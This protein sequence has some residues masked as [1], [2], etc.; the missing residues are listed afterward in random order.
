MPRLGVAPDCSYRWS[1]RWSG[2]AAAV[3]LSPASGTA[4]PCLEAAL[5]LTS[6]ARFQALLLVA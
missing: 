3:A 6:G 5:A 2:A 1:E 4:A